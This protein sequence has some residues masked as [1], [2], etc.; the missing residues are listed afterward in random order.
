VDLLR[1]WHSRSHDTGGLNV[2]SFDGH[3]RMLL[4]PGAALYICNRYQPTRNF[5][6]PRSLEHTASLLIALHFYAV[7]ACCEDM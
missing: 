6:G 3:T 5:F 7:K 4:Q 1:A 2:H